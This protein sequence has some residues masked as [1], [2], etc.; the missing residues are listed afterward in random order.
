MEYS[1]FEHFSGVQPSLL[2]EIHF[3]FVSLVRERF[4]LIINLKLKYDIW[5]DEAHFSNWKEEKKLPGL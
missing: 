4:I 3:I 5:V 2:L 1:K